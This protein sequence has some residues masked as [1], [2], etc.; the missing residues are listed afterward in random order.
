MVCT[1]V[2]G[3]FWGDEGKGKIV[4]YLALKDKVNVCVRTGSVNAAHT[5]YFDGTYYAL[6]MV[7]ATFIYDRCRLFIG[8]G[9]NIDVSQF[10]KEVERTR[11]KGRIWV[12]K[13]ASIIEQHHSAKDRKD[14]HLISLGT[15]GRGVGP[16]IQERA[17]RSAKL[18]RD[19]PELQGFLTDV[20]EEVNRAIDENLYVI[21]EG[22]QGLMLSLYHGSYP[23]V[24]SRDTSAAA[25]CSEAGVGPSRVDK[26]LVVYKC[27]ITRVGSGNLPGELSKEEA[28]RRGWFETAAGTGRE[29]RSAPFDFNLAKRVAKIHGATEAAVTKLDILYPECKNTSSFD[30]LTQNAKNFVVKIEETVGIPVTIIGTGPGA[31]DVI[32]RRV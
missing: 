5:V 13:Q 23:Y 6:H 18:A 7:P 30:Q 1:V 16:A 27:F 19:I 11:V 4:S 32:D 10:L 26:V 20:A 9:A 24:T 29:R 3:A 15:T 21:L 12:D 25:I 31:L 8:S 2:A 17:S 22:T 14:S 28:I